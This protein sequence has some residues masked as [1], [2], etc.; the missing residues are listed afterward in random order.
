MKSFGEL[1][2]LHTV[3][4]LWVDCA[5]KILHGLGCIRE[6]RLVLLVEQMCGTEP[7][8]ESGRKGILQHIL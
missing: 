2:S 6:R 5:K 3:V 7:I 8:N 4:Y 1:K